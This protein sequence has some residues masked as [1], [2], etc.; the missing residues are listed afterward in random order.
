MSRRNK[1]ISTID[2]R[3]DYVFINTEMY[4]HIPVNTLKK[5]SLDH[6]SSLY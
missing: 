3:I 2:S 6:I 4:D 1:Q 5:H